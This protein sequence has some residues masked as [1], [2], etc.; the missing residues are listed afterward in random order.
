MKTVFWNTSTQSVNINLRHKLDINSRQH[1]V[2]QI[3]VSPKT[4]LHY[5]RAQ[6][7]YASHHPIPTSKVKR[8]FK[9]A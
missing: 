7:C 2:S 4:V 1:P 3:D 9:L 5:L 6:R 8:Q